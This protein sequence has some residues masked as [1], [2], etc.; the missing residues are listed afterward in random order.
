M[1]GVKQNDVDIHHSK[2]GSIGI[3]GPLVQDIPGIGEFDTLVVH[4]ILN[5]QVMVI[6]HT[7][8][9]GTS[10]VATTLDTFGMEARTDARGSYIW[11]HILQ[12]L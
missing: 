7:E 3:F 10:T 11:T 12:R 2:C 4:R 5:I 1:I 9:Q 6:F 8:D